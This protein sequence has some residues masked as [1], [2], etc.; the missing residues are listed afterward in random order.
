MK[1]FFVSQFASYCF[2]AVD[3]CWSC[4]NNSSCSINYLSSI[5]SNS[6]SSS[7]KELDLGSMI[8]T[9]YVDFVNACHEQMGET[10]DGVWLLKQF[11]KATLR[12]GV[13]S[14]NKTC[15]FD[16]LTGRKA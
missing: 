7:S 15:S 5:N 13:N 11:L 14:Y 9:I 4:S 6:S 3:G 2:D 1:Y 8:S 10:E 12:Q 16:K